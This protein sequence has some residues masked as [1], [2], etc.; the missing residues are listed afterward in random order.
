MDENEEEASGAFSPEVYARVRKEHPS[1][2]L[3]EFAAADGAVIC[4]APTRGDYKR[5]RTMYL[6]PV[7]RPM[8]L[9]QLLA[10]SLVHPDRE[11]FSQLLER[12]PG[13]TE[14]FGEKL[15]TWA[16]LGQEATEKKL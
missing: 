6:D 2:E 7:Q 12:R 10:A 16:G 15:A 9:E 8:A 4:K 11:E 3:R 5:F 14:V 1:A 13:L